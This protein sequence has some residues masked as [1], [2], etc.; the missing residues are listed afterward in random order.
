M[1]Y[2]LSLY[3]KKD[4]SYQQVR[5]AAIEAM[6]RFIWDMKS[7]LCDSPVIAEQMKVLAEMLS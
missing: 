1:D 5:D 4:L 7:T 3:Q 2:Y 6:G